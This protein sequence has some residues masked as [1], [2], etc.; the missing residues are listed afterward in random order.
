MFASYGLT[1]ESR[2]DLHFGDT[3]AP[4]DRDVR[5]HFVMGSITYH[6]LERLSFT[7]SAAYMHYKIEQDIEY[8]DA[9]G[10]PQV[11]R[12]VPY[13]TSAQS[14]S[15]DAQYVPHDRVTLSGGINYTIG[16]SSF[17]PNAAALLAPEPISTFSKMKTKQTGYEASCQFDLAKGFSS[18]FRYRH[19]SFDDDLGN[20]YDDAFDGKADFLLL[21]LSKEW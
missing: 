4:N 1:S 5:R 15:L 21:T 11:D 9:V 17:S 19:A 14:Y 12:D 3:E 6:V 2:D 13:R 18:G 8:H 16:Q 7:A 10:T 20:P